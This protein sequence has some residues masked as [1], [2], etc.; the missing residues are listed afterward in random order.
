MKNSYTRVGDKYLQLSELGSKYNLSFSSHLALSN[1]IIAMDG[2]K[3]KLLV[4]EIED[5]AIHSYLVELDKVKSISLKKT[6]NSI[7]P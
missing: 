5:N 3:K 4:T 6:Y 2:V 7:K 1:R